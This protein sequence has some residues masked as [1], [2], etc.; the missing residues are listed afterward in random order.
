M[1]VLVH[2]HQL[3]NVPARLIGHAGQAGLRAKASGWPAYPKSPPRK[4]PWWL[5]PGALPFLR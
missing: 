1:G 3:L 2:R 5:A 4:P